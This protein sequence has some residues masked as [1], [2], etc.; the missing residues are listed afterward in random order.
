MYDLDPPRAPQLPAAGDLWGY[1]VDY[2]AR[3][4]D[5]WEKIVPSFK[6][7]KETSFF[8]MLVPTLDTVR[9]AHTLP[10]LS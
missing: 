5:S 3:R 7:D 8:E 10:T 4:M 9:Y 2:E 1:Y 6:Y